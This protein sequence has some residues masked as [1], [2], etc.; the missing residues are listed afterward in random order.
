[1]FVSPENL[2]LHEELVLDPGQVKTEIYTQKNSVFQ[3]MFDKEADLVENGEHIIESTAE[4]GK[5]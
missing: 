1:M 3:E 4:F 2:E 5:F